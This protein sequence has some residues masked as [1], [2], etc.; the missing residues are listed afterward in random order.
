MAQIEVLRMG[1]RPKRDERLTTH[2]CL[3]SRALGANKVYINT[4][5]KKPLETVES[6]NERFGGDFTVQLID[7]P[8]KILNR[9]DGK[10]INLTM[11]GGQVQ[12]FIGEIREN[13]ILVVVGSQKVP[14]W[15]Y[16]SVDYNI[17]VTN[18]PHSE[19][20]ALAVFLHE[21]FQGKQ[22]EK[23]FQGGK[24]D[25]IPSKKGEKKVKEK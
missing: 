10:I 23:D 5:D 12:N 21:F 11:Y 25:I 3:T 14:R 22:L 16:D 17:A 9:W 19:V 20:G 13:N 1:H 8:K 24:M 7:S 18:Q 15:V 4:S 6:V 2:V